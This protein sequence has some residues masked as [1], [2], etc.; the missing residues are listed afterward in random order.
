MAGYRSSS[1]R[2]GGGLRSGE[3]PGVSPSGSQI[4]RSDSFARGKSRVHRHDGIEPVPAQ[5]M[6]QPIVPDPGIGA[7]AGPGDNRFGG[8]R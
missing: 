1:D 5:G 3:R 7:A 4:G 8:G 6:P 2:P